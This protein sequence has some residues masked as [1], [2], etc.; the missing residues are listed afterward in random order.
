L[1]T[2]DSSVA[3]SPPVLTVAEFCHQ[4][5]ISLGL[6]YK[7]RIAGQGPREMIVGRRRLISAESAAEWRRA[8]EASAN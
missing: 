3:Q 5:H 2:I 8:R 7:L 4:H 1:K 6:Y